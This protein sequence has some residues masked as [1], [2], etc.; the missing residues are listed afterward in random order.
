MWLLL[1]VT[2]SYGNTNISYPHVEDVQLLGIYATEEKCQVRVREIK[3]KALNQ[4][5]P[6]PQNKEMGCLSLNGD[7]A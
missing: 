7:E 4:G 1:L 2:L 6:T 5:T 3:E